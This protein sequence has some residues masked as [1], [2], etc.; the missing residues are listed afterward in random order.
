MM[1]GFTSIEIALSRYFFLGILSFF[2]VGLQWKKFFFHT[3]KKLWIKALTLTFFV[4]IAYYLCL[5]LGLLYSSPSVATLIFG[6]CPITIALYGNFKAKE[7]SFNS[8]ILPCIAMG[9]GLV[10]VNL[11]ELDLGVGETLSGEYCF[12]LLCSVLAVILWTWFAVTNAKILKS[13]PDLSPSTWS[14]LMGI[15]TFG[16]V[17]LCIVGLALFHPDP[18]F[19]DK[20]KTWSSELGFFIVGGMALGFLSSWLGSYLWNRA[21]PLLPVSL[22]GQLTVCETI[23]GLSL[24]FLMQGEFPEWIEL[25]GILI[26]LTG[27]TLGLAAF[28]APQDKLLSTT[29]HAI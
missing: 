12:G 25:A 29:S 2:L 1:T 3:P 26:M 27:I 5:V 11:P 18:H 23:F 16:W 10:L 7:C 13:N 6:L 4:N 22:A 24:V 14:S 28:R 9:T 15:V 17:L 8:L 20:Y 19:L 21:A